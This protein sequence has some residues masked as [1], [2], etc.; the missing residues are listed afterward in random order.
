M[1]VAVVVVNYNDVED[2][3]KYV[4]TISEYDIINR[5]LVV[6]NVSTVEGALNKLKTLEN[7]K[8][9]VIQSE[10]NGGY[11]YGNNFGIKYLKSKKEEYDYYIISN[12]DIEISEKAIKHCLEVAKKDKKIAVIAPRMFD[13]D[14][15]PIRRSSWKIRTFTLDLIHST[16]LLEIIFY[17]ILRNGEYSDEDYKKGSFRRNRIF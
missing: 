8:V 5:I 9:I 11:N 3:L 15:K 13:K 14:N 1:K 17:K 12:P 7:S 6:D 4:K 10:K 16:R 2:T